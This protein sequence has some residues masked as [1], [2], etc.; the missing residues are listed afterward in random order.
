MTRSQQQG[1]WK[2]Q[3]MEAADDDF[4]VKNRVLQKIKERNQKTREVPMKKRIG[5]IVAV[6]LAFGVTSAYAAMKVYDLKNEQGEVVV[7]VEQTEN[8]TEVNEEKKSK[9]DQARDTLKPGESAAIYI[10]GP[11]NPDKRVFFTRI[12]VI[13]ETTSALQQ[14][15]GSFYAFPESLAGGY[16]FATGVVN[17][18]F[19]HRQPELFEDMYKE[20][21]QGKKDF[22]VRK[23]SPEPRIDSVATEY[24]GTKGKVTVVI[25]NFDRMQYITEE[26][27]PDETVEKVSVQKKEALYVAN[28]LPDGTDM[29]TVKFYNDN[30][31]L[32]FEV[33]TKTAAI[34]K[35]ELLAIAEKLN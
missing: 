5:L 14:E 28:K 17:Y 13:H 24:N 15:T 29:R 32:L 27:G 20:A 19:N 23:V 2:Q 33:S 30:S 3:L 1:E 31:K 9:F 12:P 34:T 22:V 10:P 25:T 7:K 4:D 11:D 26:A 16:R 35:E 6:I 8:K 18:S 21:E